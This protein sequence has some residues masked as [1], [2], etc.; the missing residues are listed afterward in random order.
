MSDDV[1]NHTG[2]F[3]FNKAHTWGDEEDGAQCDGGHSCI[4][5]KPQHLETRYSRISPH[6]ITTSLTTSQNVNDITST[7]TR[8]THP[9]VEHR[10]PQVGFEG[11]KSRPQYL[12][13][14]IVNGPLMLAIVGHLTNDV[15][16]QVYQVTLS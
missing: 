12:E 13:W 7:D 2:E 11:G 14:S 16:M 8:H 6:D 5:Q 9:E 3:P 15:L 1:I 10:R 4:G